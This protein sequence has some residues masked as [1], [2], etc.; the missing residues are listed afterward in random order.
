[1]SAL[2]PKQPFPSNA[3]IHLFVSGSSREI[4]PRKVLRVWRT[5]I[6]DVKLSHPRR[7]NEAENV[8]GTLLLHPGV[9]PMKCVRFYESPLAQSAGRLP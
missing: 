2:L 9:R 7:K 3:G 6:R 5:Y 8:C 4:T 1:V